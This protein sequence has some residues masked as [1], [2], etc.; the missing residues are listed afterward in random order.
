MR[1][2]IYNDNITRDKWME[3]SVHLGEFI[4]RFESEHELEQEFRVEVSL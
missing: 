3:F 1:I 4:A 2:E